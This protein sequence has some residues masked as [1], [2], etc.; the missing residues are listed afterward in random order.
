MEY[1]EENHIAEASVCITDNVRQKG[2]NS[3]EGV[4]VRVS[5]TLEMPSRTPWGIRTTL[6]VP[7]VLRVARSGL[8]WYGDVIV[9]LY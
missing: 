3:G 8:F 1:A 6:W 2:E 5:G 9:I 4:L 7:M